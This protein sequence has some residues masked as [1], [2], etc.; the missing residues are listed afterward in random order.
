MNPSGYHLRVRLESDRQLHASPAQR[1]ILARAVYRITK[2]WNLLAFGCAGVHLHL[3]VLGDHREVGELA[4][5]LEISL[6]RNMVFGVPFLKVHRKALEDQQHTFNA[7]TYD[8]GQRRHHQLAAD[9][10]LEATSAPDLLGA[11]LLGSH[12]IPRVR[13]HVPELKRRH[14]LDAFGLQELTQ[15]GS[16]QRPE[17]VRDAVLAAAA[18]PAFDGCSVE[19]QRAR[20]VFLA[21]AGPSLTIA[22]SAEHCATS[23]RNIQRLRATPVSSD[24]VRATK[25]QLALREQIDAMERAGGLPM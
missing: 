10:Y 12:L 7:V 16:E 20:V 22:E 18:L 19:A 4:R 24:L 5:R 15:P 8:L 2:P 17:A 14:V 25:V 23:R 6:Q 1:R 9:P 21:L 11:R 3:V 13:D